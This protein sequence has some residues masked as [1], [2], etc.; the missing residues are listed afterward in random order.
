MHDCHTT[1]LGF[2]GFP[3]LARNVSTDTTSHLSNAVALGAILAAA[4]S[5]LMTAA[6]DSTEHP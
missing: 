5:T 3:G 4:A 6:T 2:G 1:P